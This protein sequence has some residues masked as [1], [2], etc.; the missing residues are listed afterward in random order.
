M[1]ENVF[2]LLFG[3]CKIV[4]AFKQVINTFSLNCFI[5]GA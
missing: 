5:V 3:G 2:A 1:C 4:V